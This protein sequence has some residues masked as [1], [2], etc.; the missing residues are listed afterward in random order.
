MYTDEYPQAYFELVKQAEAGTEGSVEGKFNHE[1][2]KEMYDRFVS[3]NSV[4][5]QK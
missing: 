3:R 5:D 2:F 1:E 4:S